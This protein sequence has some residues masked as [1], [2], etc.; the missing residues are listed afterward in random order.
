MVGLSQGDWK[1][2]DLESPRQ[3]GVAQVAE[4]RGGGRERRR[5]EG[6]AGS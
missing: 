5:G 2:T 3:K 1:A 4:Q 6:S